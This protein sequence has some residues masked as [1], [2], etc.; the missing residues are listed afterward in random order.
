LT[1]AQSRQASLLRQ[2][3]VLSLIELACTVG[4]T[5][6]ERIHDRADDLVRLRAS[7]DNMA[8]VLWRDGQ[9]A[10]KS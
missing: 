3:L 1:P 5:P 6:N 8:S 2:R 9:K 7:I 10:G 4:S